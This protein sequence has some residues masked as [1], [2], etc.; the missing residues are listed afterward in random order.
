[1]KKIIISSLNFAN[2]IISYVWKFRFHQA[3][4]NSFFKT[5]VHQH[6]QRASVDAQPTL[7]MPL[8]SSSGSITLWGHCWSAGLLQLAVF[9]HWSYLLQHKSYHR[10]ST[11]DYQMEEQINGW[12]DTGMN[13]YIRK[14]LFTLHKVLFLSFPPLEVK[15]DSSFPFIFQHLICLKW[16]KSIYNSII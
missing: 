1:M 6:L 2:K 11:D 10:H 13:E 16:G 14:Q 9:L 8:A 5:S 12:G 3:Q 15:L 4:S 7:F